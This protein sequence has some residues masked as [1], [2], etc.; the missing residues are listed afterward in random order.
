MHDSG[1]R[2]RTEATARNSNTNCPV[3]RCLL[4]VVILNVS[5]AV[6]SLHHPSNFGT[7]DP[8]A[9]HVLDDGLAAICSGDDVADSFLGAVTRNALTRR[10]RTSAGDAV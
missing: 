2:R 8:H 7:S 6:A 1:I 5:I 9:V 3:P 10:R 4:G